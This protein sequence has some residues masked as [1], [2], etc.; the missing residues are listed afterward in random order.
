MASDCMQ[1][2]GDAPGPDLKA[3]FLRMAREWAIL[4]D[5][6]PDVADETGHRAG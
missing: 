5:R 2:A 6:D 4:A 1:L 3:H